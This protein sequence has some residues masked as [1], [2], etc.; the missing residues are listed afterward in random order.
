[1]KADSDESVYCILC[2]NS[3]N[4]PHFKTVPIVNDAVLILKIFVLFLTAIPHRDGTNGNI[5]FFHIRLT[6]IRLPE[7]INN[8]AN[9]RNVLDAFCSS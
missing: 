8:V 3:P 2:K 4:L 5:F 9:K 6:Q 7:K 1:V